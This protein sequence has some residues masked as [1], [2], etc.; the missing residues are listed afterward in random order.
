MKLQKRVIKGSKLNKLEVIPGVIYGSGIEVTSIK[1][2]TPDVTK[3]YSKY[4]TSKTF[5]ATLDN[6]THI[7]YFKEVVP[8][9]GKQ[10]EYFHFDLI[11]VSKDDKL[12]SK[13]R[14]NWLNKD[15]VEKRG[16]I[17]N[18]ILDEIEIEYNVGAGISSLSVDV[19]GLK[20]NDVLHISDIVAV[21]GVTILH[22]LD[23]A[24]LSI[25]RP[26]EEV[27]VDPDADDVVEVE[28]IKQKSEE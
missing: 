24:V 7:V 13:V 27:E 3:A 25:S 9:H 10:K 15:T 1:A 20:E 5:E 8:Q 14:L 2:S 21:D 18:G 19:T 6:K 4:G 17:I 12:T 28:S 16:F 11:K 23:A 22:E 26:K